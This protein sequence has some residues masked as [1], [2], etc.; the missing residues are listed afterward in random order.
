MCVRG[1]GVESCEVRDLTCVFSAAPVTGHSGGR[2][3]AV[4]TGCGARR[5]ATLFT[6][7]ARVSDIFTT[8]KQL[9]LQR[10][11]SPKDAGMSWPAPHV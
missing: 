2:C 8:K 1:G 7:R 5:P 9:Y 4:L 3:P 11:C 10:R 6:V